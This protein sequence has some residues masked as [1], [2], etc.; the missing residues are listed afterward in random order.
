MSCKQRHQLGLWAVFVFLKMFVEQT[1]LGEVD[2]PFRTK[3]YLLI[4]QYDKDHVSLF[5]EG[6]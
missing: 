3:E 1:S 2:S 5:G 6:K 4:L